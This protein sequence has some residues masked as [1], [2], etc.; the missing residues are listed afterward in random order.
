MVKYPPQG[1]LPLAAPGIGSP[2]WVGWT[3]GINVYAENTVTGQELTAANLPALVTAV[4]S[5]VG[6]SG[7]GLYMKRAT[8]PLPATLDLSLNNL[9]FVCEDGTLLQAAD[10]ANPAIQCLG[11]LST[12][13]FKTV[14]KGFSLVKTGTTNINT[15]LL[16]KNAH[17]LDL[18]DVDVQYFQDSMQLS[19][20][21][22]VHI[23]GG[24][25]FR[26]FKRYGVYMPNTAYNGANILL[27]DLETAT[28]Q[29]N[30][31]NVHMESLADNVSWN[32]VVFNACKFW[33]SGTG[34]YGVRLTSSGI[35]RNPV[36]GLTFNG[37]MFERTPTA[38]SIDGSAMVA[39]VELNCP[40]LFG[41]MTNGIV[42]NEATGATKLLVKSPFLSSVTNGF[43]GTNGEIRIL[44]RA[45][46]QSVTTAYSGAVHG[47]P[48][49][50][51]YH[52]DMNSPPTTTTAAFTAGRVYMSPIYIPMLL[53]ARKIGFVID[54]VNANFTVGLY[55]DN[56]STPVGGT[57][58]VQSASTAGAGTFTRM[59]NTIADTYLEEG[60]YWIAIEADAAAVCL[61]GSG[62]TYVGGSY[63]GS[64]YDRGGGYGTL[65]TPC[66]ALSG[67][68]ATASEYLL[69]G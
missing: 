22:H 66:P 23:F 65:T 47:L 28:S 62:D 16:I 40:V 44:N 13:I 56:G 10:A 19:E 61:R 60:L 53:R 12:F 37:G 31:E 24:S 30:S 3:D 43:L 39:G 35:L 21:E 27:D 2:T 58:I 64:Y 68:G 42:V 36:W 46:L 6:S 33:N 57:L 11:S 5:A 18:H 7:G 8:Y 1:N 9:E 49:P 54:S 67:T 15:G 26:D 17:S 41:P 4:K 20:S 45:Y 51:K 25:R 48:M 29:T 55:Q 14:W 50:N 32:N 69:T 52:W 38:F 63:V 59:E 34:G